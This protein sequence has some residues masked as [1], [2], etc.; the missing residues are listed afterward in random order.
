[1]S[2]EMVSWSKSAL[3]TPSFTLSLSSSLMFSCADGKPL[4]ITSQQKLQTCKFSMFQELCWLTEESHKC[5]ELAL[6]QPE[7]VTGKT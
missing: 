1:M 3:I 4:Q 5:Q 7:K 2:C 6:K